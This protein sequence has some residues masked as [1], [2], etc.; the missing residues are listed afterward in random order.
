MD[1][2]ASGRIADVGHFSAVV[3]VDTFSDNCEYRSRS[4]YVERRREQRFPLVNTDLEPLPLR[5]SLWSQEVCEALTAPPP[6]DSTPLWDFLSPTATDT[7]HMLRQYMD[8]DSDT[9]NIS[10]EASPAEGTAGTILVARS[11]VSCCT[12]SAQEHITAS[13]YSR[14]RE[15]L[16]DVLDAKQEEADKLRQKLKDIE[17]CFDWTCVGGVNYMHFAY[18]Q[19][20]CTYPCNICVWYI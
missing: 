19:G 12:S 4:G 3:G 17:V 1:D 18:M 5:Y 6:H 15:F 20:E 7:I 11:T 8:M 14:R 9:V 13:V 2:Q 10:A 16:W